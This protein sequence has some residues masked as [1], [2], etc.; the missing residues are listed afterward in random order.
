M[1]CGSFEL[2][3]PDDPDY[4]DLL[5]EIYLN[6]EFVAQISQESGF[7]SLDLEIHSRR[8]GTPW[9]FKMAEFEVALENAKARLWELRRT[10]RSVRPQN[11]GTPRRGV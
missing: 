1:K 9:Q 6:D 10:G 11:R 2:R 3:F 4:K 8:D 7:D 5:A